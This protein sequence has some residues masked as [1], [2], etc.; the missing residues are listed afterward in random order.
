M[1]CRPNLLLRPSNTWIIVQMRDGHLK[2]HNDITSCINYTAEK[3][4]VLKE[5]RD[6]DKENYKI[7]KILRKE[8]GN[9]CFLHL[10]YSH[11]A[12]KQVGIS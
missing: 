5:Q 4:K 1:P 7:T 9:V 2:R 11:F 3:A 6:A 10:L 12:T 8:Q